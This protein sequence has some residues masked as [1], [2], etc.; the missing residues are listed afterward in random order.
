MIIISRNG[1]TGGTDFVGG[2]PVCGNS[3]AAYKNSVYPAVFHDRGGHVVADQGD[4]HAGGKQLIG[5]KPCSLQQRACF[6]RK[7][8]EMIAAFFSQIYRGCCGSI[9]A[10][11]Q[12]SRIAVG[13]DSVPRLYQAEAIFTD[14]PADPDIFFFYGNGFFP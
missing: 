1:Y 9:F 5:G 13:E 6:V 14:G 11:S 8:M 4:V 2:I 10:G 7:H 12:L 3:V